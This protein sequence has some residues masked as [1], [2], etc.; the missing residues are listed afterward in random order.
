[1]GAWAIILGA[2]I[3][4]FGIAMPSGAGTANLDVMNFK[5]NLVV[6]GAALFLAGV[7]QDAASHIVKAL[8][9]LAKA[10]P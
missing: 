4:L 2:L 1:M 9:E 5:T 7:V 10:K 3:V 8:R 6:L